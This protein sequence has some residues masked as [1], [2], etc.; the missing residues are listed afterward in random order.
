MF[1]CSAILAPLTSPVLVEKPSQAAA[2]PEKSSPRERNSAVAFP[3]PAGRAEARPRPPVFSFHV[4][5]KTR[6]HCSQLRLMHP[7]GMY[8]ELLPK[9][10]E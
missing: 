3:L 7:A 10:C 6:A 2:L 5:R 8:C 4:A 9:L 1:Y